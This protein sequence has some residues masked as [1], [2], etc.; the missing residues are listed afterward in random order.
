[1]LVAL[2]DDVRVALIKL[3]E[4][5]CAIRLNTSREPHEQ[6]TLARE[7]FEIYAPLA[8]RLGIGHLKWELED[9]AFRYLEPLSYKRIAKLLDEKRISRQDY[10]D[11]FVV[12]L[13]KKLQSVNI[14]ARLEGRAK[15]IY[16]IWKKMRHKGITFSEVYDVRA[17]RLLVDDDNDCYRALGVVHN[18]WRNIPGEFDDYIANPKENGYRSLHTAVIGPDGKVLEI[19]IRTEE[20]H[21]EAE[22]GVCSHWLYKVPEGKTQSEMYE[23]RLEWLRQ[24]LDWQDEFD[25]APD[26]AKEIL[27]DVAMDRVYMYTP[28]GHVVDMSPGSTPVDFAYRVHTEVGH[29][30]RGA[31]VNGRVV[32][33]NT[34]LKSGDKVEIIN[35]DEVAPRREWLHEH[36]GYISTSRAR[37]KIQAWFG[38]RE[39]QKNIDDGKKLLVDELSQLGVEKLDFEQLAEKLSEPSL[40]ALFYA[41]GV[42]AQETSEVVDRAVELAEARDN[43]LTLGFV[44]KDNEKVILS[45][46][47]GMDY[48]ISE[49]CKPV[50]GDSIVGVIDDDS[51]VNVHLQDC[52]QALKADIYGRLIRLDWQEEVSSTF[53]VSIEVSAYDRS[54]LLYDITGIF[55]REDTNVLSIQTV[56]DKQ[57]NMVIL[58]MVIEVTKLSRLLGTLERIE[59]LPNV[60]TARRTI[61]S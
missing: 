49:C 13:A 27:D 10:I 9:L 50:P 45:G 57:N 60:I 48:I 19:Q 53:P 46:L 18:L 5:T 7:V 30:C 54:G 17:I 6:I 42:G 35:G 22:Y 24:I 61:T 34:A 29:K 39:K 16:S 52:L 40:G 55:M 3:A 12:E 15:H 31:K 4:R 2:V 32:P 41:I 59:Q 28:E 37:A 20:M 25:D 58:K 11:Q 36:L 33:L 51:L 56:S 38:Q 21:E 8:H 43:Q 44:E 1:M 23:E 14:D 26:L 47:G